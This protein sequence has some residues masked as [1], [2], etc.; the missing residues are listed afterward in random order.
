MI[1]HGDEILRTQ[2]GNNNVYCQDNPLAWMDWDLESR[3]AHMLAFFR[4]AI[5][6][7]KRLPLL[8]GKRFL[9]GQD[10]DHNEIPDIA[11][12]GP[13][14]KPVDWN[15]PEA[16]HLAFQLDGYDDAESPEGPAVREF[17]RYYF[18]LNAGFEELDFHLPPLLETHAWHRLVDTSLDDGNDF[19]DV[20]RAVPLLDQ[21]V[22]RAR[23]HSTVILVNKLRKG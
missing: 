23:T 11:W 13:D 9:T 21:L 15:N 4:K 10:A 6:L 17:G 16:R 20:T 1:S 7:R 22:Y 5:A 19:L 3:N 2:K 12:Y 18:I 14:G 8:M